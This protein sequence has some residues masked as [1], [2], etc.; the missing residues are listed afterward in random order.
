MET[1]NLLKIHFVHLLA[2]EKEYIDDSFVVLKLEK[3]LKINYEFFYRYN[4]LK[5]ITQSA[6]NG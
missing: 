6:E 5:F 2:D 4:L 1:E 3:F